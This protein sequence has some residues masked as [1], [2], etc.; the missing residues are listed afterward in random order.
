MANIQRRPYLDKICSGPHLM[1]QRPG[2][3]EDTVILIPIL[4]HTGIKSDLHEQEIPATAPNG[5]ITRG[6]KHHSRKRLQPIYRDDNELSKREIVFKKG[7]K[8]FIDKV[9][10]DMEEKKRIQFERQMKN[11]RSSK[12]SIGFTDSF[13]SLNPKEVPRTEE[14]NTYSRVPTA[15]TAAEEDEYGADPDFDNLVDDVPVGESKNTSFNDDKSKKLSLDTTLPPLQSKQVSP[16][17]GE[18]F[19]ANSSPTTKPTRS[20]SVISN[21]GATTT[22][23]GVSSPSR[24][25]RP[26]SRMSLFEN[27]LETL[28]PPKSPSKRFGSLAD[29]TAAVRDSFNHSQSITFPPESP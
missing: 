13:N 16:K 27:M 4:R 2:I 12:S 3:R 19:V 10:V 24:L 18:P 22:C 5:R 8:Q 15:S 7:H 23:P 26:Y 1:S 9:L 21:S 28:E 17:T 20:T 14:A 6:Y 29:I 11:W 25:S